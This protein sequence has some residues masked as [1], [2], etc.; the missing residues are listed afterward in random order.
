MAIVLPNRE[1]AA[2][3]PTLC[4]DM[5]LLIAA[6]ARPAPPVME[7]AI[8]APRSASFGWYGCSSG[9]G[10]IVSEGAWVPTWIR[11]DGERRAIDRREVV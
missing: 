9:G 4:G 7:P 5:A 11:S 8:A 10:F 3:A 1:K 6:A 2:K